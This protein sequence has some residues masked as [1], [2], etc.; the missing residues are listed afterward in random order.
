MA[1]EKCARC[2]ELG[3]DRRTLWMAA[4][5]DMSTLGPP[6][7]VAT[8][9]HADLEHVT[10]VAKMPFQVNAGG[11]KITLAPAVLRYEGEITP[12]QFFTLRVCKDCR[13]D[14]LGAIADWFASPRSPKGDGDIPIRELGAVKMITREEWERRRRER[15]QLGG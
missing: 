2:D 5:W 9:F 7:E 10:D 12:H 15:E 14:W 1:D 13:A 11:Q 4:L 8:L 6:F 3:A